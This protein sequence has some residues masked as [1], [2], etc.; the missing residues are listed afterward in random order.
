MNKKILVPLGQNDRVEAL[1][2]YVEQVARSGMNVVFLMRY[3]V[4]GFVGLEEEFGM[5]A[6]LEA[7]KLALHYYSWEENLHRAAN[8]VSHASEVL[9][10]KGI[11]VKIEIY[12]GSLKQALRSK[13][14][15]PCLIIRR[16]GI[17]ECAAMFFCR[18]V[19]RLFKRPSFC[20]VEL[21]HPSAVG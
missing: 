15:G 13:E 7:K 4:G 18:A 8:R 5:K 21:I 12:T 16:M 6:A 1:I 19:D 2:P 9:G 20:P 3:P 11:E 14:S 10:N 17:G